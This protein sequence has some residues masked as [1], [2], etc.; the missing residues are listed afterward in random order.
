MGESHPGEGTPQ[1]Y[2]RE[3]NEQFYGKEDPWGVREHTWNLVKSQRAIKLLPKGHY[4]F[5][6]DLCCGEGFITKA[7]LGPICDRVLGL[8]FV[9]KAVERARRKNSGRNI[10]YQTAD[11]LKYDYGSLHPG[12]DLVHISDAIEYF[13]RNQLEDLLRKLAGI[14][15]SPKV[16][17]AARLL[18]RQY[19]LEHPELVGYHPEHD[20]YG[21]W[22][23]FRNLAG[24]HFRVAA[25]VPVYEYPE[26]RMPWGDTA[27]SAAAR[28]AFHFMMIKLFTR[29]FFYHRA[30]AEMDDIRF[31]LLKAFGAAPLTGR[32]AGRM[33]MWYAILLEPKGAEGIDA[34]GRK[35]DVIACPA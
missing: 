30:P 32:L 21:S 33:M 13:N 11:V 34:A 6:L 4:G 14:E 8:D 7:V 17:L 22:G 23:E 3:W 29:L 2:T 25:I 24:R 19:A 5:C 10:S 1:A 9:A 16:L 27:L 12:P 26:C 20:F 31:K 28:R 35:S 15:S 18:Q